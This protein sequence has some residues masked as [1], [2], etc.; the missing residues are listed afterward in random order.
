MTIDVGLGFASN[1]AAY[2][3]AR[4]VAPWLAVAGDD[5]RFRCFV[6]F[7]ILDILNDG[8]RAQTVPDGVSRRPAFT[9][10][11]VGTSASDGVASVGLDLPNTRS[12]AGVPQRISVGSVGGIGAIIPIG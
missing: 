7:D 10:I 3:R 5:G 12:R 1:E 11:P 2:Q 9:F 6:F 4:T 8:F